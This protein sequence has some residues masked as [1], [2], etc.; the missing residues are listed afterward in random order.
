MLQLAFGSYDSYIHSRQVWGGVLPHN[1]Q[2]RHFKPALKHVPAR[3]RLYDPWHPCAT[4]LLVADES[5]KVVSER[6][7]HS[8]IVLT[9]VYAM[10]G[11]KQSENAA[12]TLRNRCKP[13]LPLHFAP[14]FHYKFVH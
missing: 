1:V 10:F 13:S 2:S 9:R 8:S 7:G 4:P 11:F 6:L 5:Q 12:V 14:F 3:L